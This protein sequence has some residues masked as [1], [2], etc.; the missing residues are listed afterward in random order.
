MRDQL[1]QYVDLLFAGAKEYS[2]VKQEILQN[3][4]DRYDDLISE[5]KV[6][7]AAYRL[8]ITGIGDINEILGTTPVQPVSHPL[9]SESQA[10]VDTPAKKKMRALAIGLY[11]VAAIP[12]ILLDSIGSDILGL[13]ITLILVAIATFLLITNSAPDKDD[14]VEKERAPLSPRQEMKESIDKL[15]FAVGL[16]V[17]LVL[18]FR[19][20]AWYITW[21]IFPIIGALKELISAVLDLLEVMKHEN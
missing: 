8:A 21:L 9:V 15:I 1:I 16:V 18:S 7:E 13:C 19:T 3:T 5:G 20:Q 4:L 12:L 2:D 10:E 14:K 17:Y 6:P 11:I